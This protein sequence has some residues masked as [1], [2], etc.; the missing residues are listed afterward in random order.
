MAN[1]GQIG[2]AQGIAQQRQQEVVERDGVT[3]YMQIAA[4]RIDVLMCV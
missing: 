2:I 4:R 1:T 3:A